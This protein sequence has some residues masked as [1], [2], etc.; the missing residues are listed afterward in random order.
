MGP[1]HRSPIVLVREIEGSS[2]VITVSKD[3]R[4]VLWSGHQRRQIGFFDLEGE[5]LSAD[6]NKQSNVLAVSRAS[7]LVQFYSISSFDTPFVFREFRLTKGT[8]IEQVVFSSNGEELAALSAAEQRVYYLLTSVK[9]PFEVL[10]YVKLAHH[11]YSINWHVTQKTAVKPKH[12]HLLVCIGYG[13]LLINGPAAVS[14]KKRGENLNLQADIYA[15]RTDVDQRLVSNLPSGEII[16]TGDD[17]FIK[18]YRQP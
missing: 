2:L 11:P 3:G 13:V 10:G 5:V 14:T 18:K 16:T 7:G 1:Y 8:P 6:V 9:N 12:E 4:A 17:K 15:I